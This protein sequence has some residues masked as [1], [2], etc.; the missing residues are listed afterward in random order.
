[1]MDMMKL[2]REAKQMQAQVEQAQAEIANSTYEGSS[3]GGVVTA[4]VS[5]TGELKTIKLAPETVDPSDIEMLED[6]IVAAVRGAQSAAEAA[7]EAAMGE[8]RSM[9]QGLNLPGLPDL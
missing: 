2:L 1:M 6:L 5:G 3:G 8:V 9:I 4:T 7:R